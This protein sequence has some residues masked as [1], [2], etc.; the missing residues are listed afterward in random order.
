MTCLITV[1]NIFV[2]RLAH[3]YA[4]SHAHTY[5]VAWWQ[6][7]QHRWQ[8]YL[9]IH[10]YARRTVYAFFPFVYFS[11]KFPLTRLHDVRNFLFFFPPPFFL[12][13]PSSRAQFFMICERFASP[14]SDSYVEAELC[15]VT[16]LGRSFSLL[17][18][19]RRESWIE[20]CLSLLLYS[21][22]CGGTRYIL[23][24]G[25]S[26]RFILSVAVV[27]TYEI[28]LPFTDSYLGVPVLSYHLALDTPALYPLTVFYFQVLWRRDIANSL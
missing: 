16:F 17:L 26:F 7:G 13:S 15:P 19:L 10:T 1:R 8:W 9:T 5:V 2:G 24:I 3:V 25:V 14:F 27:S 20:A 22:G 21:T 6:V 12:F 28:T 18:L 11:A 23:S 4:H